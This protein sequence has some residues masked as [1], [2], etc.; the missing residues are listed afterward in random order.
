MCTPIGLET[1]KKGF[2]TALLRLPKA[3]D[4]VIPSLPE[5]NT[6]LYPGTVVAVVGWGDG[7]KDRDAVDALQLVT[8]LE[9]VDNKN[10][11]DIPDCIEDHMLCAYA[12]SKNSCKGG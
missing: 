9:V 11:P 10:C 2:D 3:V 1:S 6:D 7:R 5:E 8:G 4:E 12:P